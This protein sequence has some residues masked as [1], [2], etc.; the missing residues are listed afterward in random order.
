MKIR[1]M[2]LGIVALTTVAAA[3]AVLTLR[4]IRLRAPVVPGTA[5][6]HA[7]GSR[8]Q[9]QVQSPTGGKFD[10][11]LAEL[12]RVAGRV[13]P[14][15]PLAGLHSLSPAARFKLAADDVTPLV[16]IDAVTV[17]DPR[18]LVTALEALG[19][20]HA[21]LFA[22]DVSGWLPVGALEAAA[23]RDEVLS[24]RAAMPHRRTGAVTS[25]GDFVQ[26]SA[27]VRSSDSLTG[28]GVTVGVLSDSFNCYAV[29]ANPANDVPV[30]GYSG[31]AFNGFTADYATDESTGDLPAG[32][33]VLQEADCLNYDAPLQPPFGDEG[34]AMLQIVHDV[35]PGASLA[36]YTAEGSGD[37][38]FANGIT[39]L[40]A[41]GAKVI[42]DDVGYFDEP[43][44]QDGIIAQAID[45]VE[46]GG[47]AYFSA[48]GN[49]ADAAY[50][51]TA[52][53][54]GATPAT[55]GPNA[56]EYLLNVDTSGATTSTALPVTL[57]AMQPGDLTAIV[58]EWD[59][60]YVTGAPHSGGATGKLDLCVTGATS[61]Y[62]IQ[63]ADGT[64]VTC[65]G[66]NALG[67]D[68]VQIL[69]IA[70]PANASSA[71]PQETLDLV[72]GFAGG[73]QPG[74]VKVAVLTDGQTQPPPL[75]T[76][77][78]HSGTIQ[79][80]PGAAGAAA[81]GAAFYF[82]T[83]ACGTT[84]AQLEAYSSA[85]GT[86]ILFDST[87]T[88]LAAPVVRQKPD[89]AAPDGGNDTFL[90]FGLSDANVPNTNDL[91]TTSIA[92]CQNDASF[93]NFFGTSAATPHAAG[94]A[95]LML[96]ANS[97][98]T[99]A[100]IQG[101]LRTSA[102]P[103]AGATPNFNSGYG[104]V[105]ADAAFALIPPGAP[106]IS[107]SAA[108]VV[109]GTAV[110]LTWTSVNTSTCTAS[111]SWSGAQKTAGTAAVT[112]TAAGTATYG[113]SCSNAAGASPVES[114]TVTVT[115]PATGSG[116][117]GSL[118]WAALA[119]LMGVAGA[120]AGR[121]NRRAAHSS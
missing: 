14:A 88:R 90:G 120:A 70:N 21:S 114:A 59:Q 30:S 63:N 67:V 10:G 117:G 84:P 75:S 42:A 26:H 104:F 13:D 85:G 34:R 1:F 41:A 52:P 18:R 47:V 56:G 25:Q 100:Q 66:P 16:A 86:P 32:V 2:S 5:V 78:T 31:Y 102:L 11:A 112:P 51:N 109:A 118:D 64:D 23:A 106:A 12:S 7:Y 46:A 116:G 62:T 33:D 15:H 61:I 76:F 36:F 60:P 89:Y 77:A 95:A 20:Q 50:E 54:F 35:A 53:S 99:P 110:T 19:L 82:Y 103:M 115:A 96:Q 69:I 6:L 105:Q 8:S 101:A 91:L 24:L 65:T 57:A 28:T 38:D 121:R 73:T 27:A 29:Y 72:V 97:A 98:L 68:P 43:F 9:A 4:P 17:G 83:P 79:G 108:S 22:N 45:T 40:A 58:L 3:S 87:G 55:T 92:A 119:A 71:T 49:D 39:A 80:H 74:R 81:V 48:A 111:G 107:A 93:P 94:I 44:Y 37:A 113:L